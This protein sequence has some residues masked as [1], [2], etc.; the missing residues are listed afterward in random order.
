MEEKSDKK[1][2][3]GIVIGIII[4]VIVLGLI[5]LVIF[6]IS[7]RNVNSAISNARSASFVDDYIVLEKQVKVNVANDIDPSCDGDCALLY[8]YDNEDI[9]FEVRDM[10]TYYSLEFDVDD[11][12]Y[13]NFR[14]NESD[15]AV[16]NNAVCDE[17]EIIGRINK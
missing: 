10:G 8:E 16:L 1:M 17:N 12:K 3:I 2:W 9:D 15:C 11:D 7:T 6:L 14:F 13:R 4:G 5:F